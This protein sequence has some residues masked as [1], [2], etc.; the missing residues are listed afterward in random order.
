MNGKRAGELSAELQKLVQLDRDQRS[1]AMNRALA[2][3]DELSRA[4]E[5]ICALPPTHERRRKL[6]EALG[7]G[8]PP[9]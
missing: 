2:E 8:A 9:A 5:E 1:A 4:I 3:Q 6:W 7:L